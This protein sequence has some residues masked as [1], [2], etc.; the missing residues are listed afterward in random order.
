MDEP[1]MVSLDLMGEMASR[2]HIRQTKLGPI[3]YLW[4]IAFYIQMNCR[5]DLIIN[6]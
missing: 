1:K 6:S 2:A 4:A 3:R 5:N